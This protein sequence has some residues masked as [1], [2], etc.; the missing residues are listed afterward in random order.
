MLI[1]LDDVADVLDISS[2][3]P[4]LESCIII[5]EA[6]AAAYIGTDTLEQ[7]A[8][9]ESITPP[10]DRANLEVSYG[11]ITAVGAVTDKDGD[12][13]HDSNNELTFDNWRIKLEDGFCQNKKCLLEYT[14]GW[15]KK[16]EGASDLPARVRQ[17]I[18]IIACTVY[19]RGPNAGSIT[20]ERL[21]DWAA[22]YAE[23][24]TGKSA[25]LPD[26]AAMLLRAYR[27]ATM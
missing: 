13:L 9:S 21:G 23:P 24:K 3:D 25:L 5:A 4:K 10:R 17:A 1:D 6:M 2:E 22:T 20:S 18:V 27:R 7:T 15:V 26:D 19:R 11:P 14:T 12:S 8:R 16:G